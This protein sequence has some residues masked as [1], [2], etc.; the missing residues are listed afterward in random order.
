MEIG[1]RIKEFRA[2]KGITQEELASRT[3]LSVRTIQRIENGEVDPRYH[4]LNVIAEALEVDYT[5]LLGEQELE[6][7]SRDSDDDSKWLALLHLSGLLVFLVPPLLIWIWKK[8]QIPN[9]NKHA[10]DVLNFQLSMLIYLFCGAIL[11]VIIIGLP[12]LI[13][14][15]IYSTVI[16]I[17]NSVKVMNGQEYRYPMTL[18]L[19]KKL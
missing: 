2:Q 9:I 16:I 3:G 10:T 8:D 4:S 13:F 11:L 17:L 6:K 14:L 12:I 1:Q 19:I 5:E 7:L 18:N 15:G